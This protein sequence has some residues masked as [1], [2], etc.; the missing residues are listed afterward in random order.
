[1]KKRRIVKIA[2]L[3]FTFSLIMIMLAYFFKCNN[4]YN[5]LRIKGFY[6]E[7]KN[8]LDVVFIG[9]SETYTAFAPGL[10]WKENGFTSYL[11]SVSG[12][13]IS[14]VKS[15]IVEVK[16]TQKPKVIVVEINGAVPESGLYQTRDKGIRSY[17]DNIPWSENKMRTIREVIPESEQAS[18]YLPF[19]KYHSNWK[20]ISKCIEQQ[21][22]FKEMKEQG[23]SELKGLQTNTVYK[24][25]KNLVDIT[26]DT[27][28][29]PLSEEAEYYLRDLLEYCK[30]EKL[31]NILF[32]RMP[33][34]VSEERY[35]DFQRSNTAG[36]IIEEYGFPFVNFEYEKEEIG[37]DVRK[38]FY[39]DDHMNI[40]GCRK[41]TSYMGKYLTEHYDLSGI[42]HSEKLAAHWDE[43]ARLTEEFLQRAEKMYQSGKQKRMAEGYW[44][45]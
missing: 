23:S 41:F 29:L 44:R 31:D 28:A 1:M 18:Y 30:K 15:Q 10:A 19:L 2:S 26:G 45:D 39:N 12:C 27:S 43:T 22:C 35:G 37:L 21:R 7:E 14:M 40:Y 42:A 8:S 11:Y 13:P 3:I 20:N 5:T 9:A 32:I 16:K 36:R 34:R 17:L 6:L 24:R 25:A 38:D 33:H 4:I